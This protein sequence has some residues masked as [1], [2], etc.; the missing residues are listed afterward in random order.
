LEVHPT[1]ELRKLL[2]H[3][4]AF[5]MLIIAPCAQQPA[6]VLM[7]ALLQSLVPEHSIGSAAGIS[8]GIAMLMGTVSPALIGFLLQ[9][10]GFGVVLVFLLLTIMISGFLILVL[11]IIRIL[12]D[13]LARSGHRM[14]EPAASIM[15]QLFQ[16]TY[17]HV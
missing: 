13:I 16:C 15:A 9:T 4:W 10:S 14:A 7:H 1:D 12:E 11:A 3:N 5:V 2:K 6:I 8:G 17:S